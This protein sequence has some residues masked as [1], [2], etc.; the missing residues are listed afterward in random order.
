MFT[1][2]LTSLGLAKK[3]DILDADSIQCIRGKARKLGIDTGF[4]EDGQMKVKN[5]E[6]SL[7]PAKSGTLSKSGA[8]SYFYR[9]M[10]RD[11]PRLYAT[12]FGGV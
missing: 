5:P 4:S 12:L 11:K 6:Y 3:I 8:S 10:R 1:D 7:Q 9:C 2:W